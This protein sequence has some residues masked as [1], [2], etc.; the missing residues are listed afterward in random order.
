[1]VVPAEQEVTMYV[2][3]FVQGW[4]TPHPGTPPTKPGVA[5]QP[6]PTVH[7]KSCHSGVAVPSQ[8]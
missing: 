2:H 1:M 3:M 7:E 6:T 5:V 4:E 8:L